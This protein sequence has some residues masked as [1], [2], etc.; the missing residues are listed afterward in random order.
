M[1]PDANIPVVAMSLQDDLNPG[2]HCQLGRALS[3]LR[4]EGV[5]ILGS[6]MGYHNLRDFAGQAPASYAFHDWL[7]QALS[8]NWASRTD[9]LSHWRVAPGGLSSHPRE[10]HLLPLMVASGAGSDAPGQAIW[11][12]EIGPTCAGAWAFD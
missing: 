1:Y 6:G 3:S 5:L 10:E 9:Q 7:D 4:D 2:L 8:G 12:G 11:R